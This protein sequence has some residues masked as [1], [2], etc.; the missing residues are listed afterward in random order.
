MRSFED[1]YTIA[2]ERKGGKEAL[3]GHLSPVVDVETLSSTPLSNWLEAMAKAIFQ[4]GFSWKVI[5]AKWPG[6]QTAFESFEPSRVATFHDEDLDRLL[7][8]KAIVRNGQ[9]INAV[10]ENARFLVDLHKETGDASKYLAEW[11][12]ED[13]AGFLDMLSKRGSRLGGNTGQRVCRMVGR[14]S[15]VTSPDVCKRLLME[16]VIE[17]TPPTTKAASKAIQ[18]AFNQ[19]RSESGRSLT[20]ISRILAYS[21]D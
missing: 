15:Y 4:A 10:M 18:S 13:Q 2:T 5:D 17:K 7:S 16:K 6:F 9:K 3:E 1:I 12:V 21:V 20:D 11:P 19:W 14:D 8:D